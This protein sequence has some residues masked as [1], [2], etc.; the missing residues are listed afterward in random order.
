MGI[1][2][3]T[4]TKYL[5]ARDLINQGF[6]INEA[7]KKVCLSKTAY[8]SADKELAEFKQMAVEMDCLN[9]IEDEVSAPI[10]E[11]TKFFAKKE[12]LMDIGANIF[13]SMFVGTCVAIGAIV[14][15]VLSLVNKVKGTINRKTN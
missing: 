12:E 10:K 1:K 7:C 11:N 5:L 14:S 6:S 3:T 8:R 9:C 4:R 15:V 13:I 2:S